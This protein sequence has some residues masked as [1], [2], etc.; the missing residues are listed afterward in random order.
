M[1]Q[2]SPSGYRKEMQKGE[3]RRNR[4]YLRQVEEFIG[5]INSLNA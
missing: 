2:M 1:K 3:T 5:Q 4:E